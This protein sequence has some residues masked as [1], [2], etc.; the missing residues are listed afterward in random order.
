SAGAYYAVMGMNGMKLR[1]VVTLGLIMAL[2]TGASGLGDEKEGTF[3]AA[4]NAPS[5]VS[6]QS[7]GF[8]QDAEK[9]PQPS[10][11]EAPVATAT[12]ADSPIAAPPGHVIDHHVVHG[13]PFWF[14]AD[15]VLAWFEGSGLPPL[16]TT[17]PAGT[18]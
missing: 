17:S 8:V 1:I 10:L 2:A 5:P 14:S 11:V 6:S 16:V 13:E 12:P 15:Y 18:A 7:G 9:A 3:R 4:K